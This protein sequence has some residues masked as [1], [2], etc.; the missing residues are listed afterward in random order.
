ME[1]DA[2]LGDTSCIVVVNP[3]TLEYLNFAVVHTD[4]EGNVNFAHRFFQ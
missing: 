3:E 2:A 1:A 4:G